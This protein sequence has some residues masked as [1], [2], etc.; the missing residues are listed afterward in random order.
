[1]PASHGWR[2]WAVPAAVVGS[3]LAAGAVLVGMTAAL[4]GQAWL[5]ATAE[6]VGSDLPV[7][8]LT[9]AFLLAGLLLA[10]DRL[11]GRRTSI[12]RRLTD[13]TR[14]ILEAN[15]AHRVAEEGPAELREL[16]GAVNA[17]ADRR[18]AAETDRDAAIAEARAEVETEQRI[19]ATLVAELTVAVV[20]CNSDGRILLYNEAARRLAGAEAIGLGRSVHELIDPEL[21]EHADEWLAERPADTSLS[22]TTMHQG[23]LLNVTVAPTTGPD[24]G[25]SGHVL[26]LEE[27]TD[28]EREEQRREGELRELTE[29]ARSAVGSIQ[30][31]VETIGQHP[32]MPAD[33]R[34]T[35]LDIVHE[36]AQRLGEHLDR[37]AQQ[38]GTGG[39]G[40]A[41]RTAISAADLAQLCVRALERAGLGVR[42]E[43]QAP[44]TWLSL[45][46]HALSRAVGRLGSWIESER[47]A[48][49]AAAAE[50]EAA[51]AGAA[52]SIDLALTAA[53][54]QV[55][56][57]LAWTGPPGA[58][59]ATTWLESSPTPD[60]PS[61]RDVVARHGG[62]SWAVGAEDRTTV[63]VVLGALAPSQAP[64]PPA[65]T[66]APPRPVSYDFDLFTWRDSAA[67]WEDRDLAELRYTVFDTET[68]G[69]H[70]GQGDEIISIGA[71][72]VFNG[73]V[74]E[75]EFFDQLVDPGRSI[76][77]QSTAIH[78][79]TREMTRGQPGIAEVL[80][81]FSRFAADTV[82]IGHDVGFDLQFLRR[83]EAAIAAMLEQ[84]VL[85]TLLLDALLHPDHDSHSLEEISARLGIDVR[86]RHSALGDATTT[87]QVLTRQLVLLRSRGIRTLGEVVEASSATL[88]AR[89]SQELYGAKE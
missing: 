45:E 52:A 65:G 15:T 27:L 32:D 20:V 75:Q 49:G 57:E 81:R 11:L 61:L 58:T 23:K 16:A 29:T 39:V 59:E 68:T 14:L 44:T 67:A 13:E 55:Q 34:R 4:G 89:R 43:C 60:A 53:K 84:P 73:R 79:I 7:I 5:T 18:Q 19:L 71:V 76:P 66:P 77:A 82:L 54:D 8:L 46:S 56:L 51:D 63:V 83:S 87:A 35:F 72:R 30:A 86:G 78:G 3:A 10:V 17:L 26:V 70:P 33:T 36:E 48:A 50:T 1:M 22:A 64:A 6:A 69:L 12:A 41:G 62:E 25:S 74:L 80:P 31:A 38:A 40:G 24:G 9:A 42:A 21:V 28:R 88:H 37:R 85:D 47:Q 2:R